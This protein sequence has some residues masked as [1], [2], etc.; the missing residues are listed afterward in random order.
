MGFPHQRPGLRRPLLIPDSRLVGIREEYCFLQ[1]RKN[2]GGRSAFASGPSPSPISPASDLYPFPRAQVL[3]GFHLSLLFLSCPSP[4]PSS[5]AP[6][7]LGH[8]FFWISLTS[9]LAQG[10]CVSGSS[11]WEHAF[12]SICVPAS[13]LFLALSSI[14]NFLSQACHFVLC[15]SVLFTALTTI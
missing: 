15:C 8:P 12:S 3:T 6:Q 11:R 1:R 14:C 7:S 4:T 5:S 13:F 9:S 2:G 10:L